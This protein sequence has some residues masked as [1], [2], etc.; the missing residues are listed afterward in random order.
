MNKRELFGWLLATFSSVG[1]ITTSLLAADEIPK[2]KIALK[3]KKE[4]KGEEDLTLL[5]T[6]KVVTPICAPSL[7][8]GGLTIGSI[9]TNQALN[10]K[11]QA[12]LIAS[13]VFASSAAQE[14][15]KYR[16]AIQA[17]QGEA[18][19]QRAL[20]RAKM[21][22][23]Q[24]RKEIER[25]KAENGPYLYCFATLPGMM[26]EARPGDIQ[27][28]FL[29]FNRNLIL[30]GYNDLLEL[31]K[32]IGVPERCYDAEESA[33]YGWNEYINS[34][35][36]ECPYCDFDIVPIL[37]DNGNYV[38]LIKTPV[39]PYNLDLDY[40]NESTSDHQYPM[41]DE[42]MTIDNTKRL[43]N[44]NNY[45]VIKIDHPYLYRTGII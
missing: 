31:Y 23:K 7:I 14:Y 34:V 36:F 12:A 10:S 18:V 15:D 24:L 41:Y 16:R 42:Q 44:S 43:F 32:F 26:F 11:Q 22:E 17:E 20:E 40:E 28:A 27:E 1:V 25:L 5:E 35:E 6:I 38:H 21:T 37:M 9:F 8:S 45:E 33:N 39:P 4:A 13:G 2:A 3:V 29:H 30:R 19:D